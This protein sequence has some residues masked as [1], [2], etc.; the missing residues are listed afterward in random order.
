M[1][2]SRAQFVRFERASGDGWCHQKPRFRPR[3]GGFCDGVTVGDGTSPMNTIF[4]RVGVERLKA[5]LA[6]TG[7]TGEPPRG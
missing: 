1:I 4:P 5:S 6:V 7:V 3:Q 2:E